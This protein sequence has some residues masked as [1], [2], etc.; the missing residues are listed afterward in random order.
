MFQVF[1]VIKHIQVRKKNKKQLEKMLSPVRQRNEWEWVLA[2][3]VLCALMLLLA[4]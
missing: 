4:R 1:M 3:V 2:I